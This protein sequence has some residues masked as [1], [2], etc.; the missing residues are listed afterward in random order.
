[1]NVESIMTER[2]ATI[3]MDDS[4]DMVKEVFDNAPFNHLLVV[5]DEEILIGVISDRDLLSSISPHLGTLGENSRDRNTLK[6]KSH[7]IMSRD[8][9]TVGKECSVGDAA[10]RILAMPGSCLPVVDDEKKIEGI[11]SWKDILAA[12]I[13]EPDKEKVIPTV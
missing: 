5:D 12:M 13:D 9:I 10:R 8:P 7:Q 6:K 11:L 3:N 4:L 1:M 2:V